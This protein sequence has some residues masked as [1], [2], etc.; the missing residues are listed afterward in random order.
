[1]GAMIIYG[2]KLAIAIAAAA[3]FVVSIVAIAN[4]LSAINFTGPIAEIF[5]IIGA[6]MPWNASAFNGI[7]TG[8][9]IVIST[10]VA[11]FVWRAMNIWNKQT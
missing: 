7:F 10:R 6:F 11:F 5:S 4:V 8:L 2:I 3:I 1:M 9:I